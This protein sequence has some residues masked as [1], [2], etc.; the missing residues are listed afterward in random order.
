MQ[1]NAVIISKSLNEYY[2]KSISK[3]CLKMCLYHAMAFYG[4]IIFSIRS[5]FCLDYDKRFHSNRIG[6]THT[7]EWR[8]TDFCIEAF[9]CSV[10]V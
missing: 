3:S 8:L 9:S 10:P 6:R 1:L 4:K 2:P 5:C 7:C